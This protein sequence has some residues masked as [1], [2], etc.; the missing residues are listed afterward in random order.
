MINS[1]KVTIFVCLTSAWLVNCTGI[2]PGVLYKTANTNPAK[3]YANPVSV[4]LSGGLL[5]HM[6]SVPGQLGHSVENADLTG[7]ACSK[8]FLGL[9]AIGDSSIEAAK[10]EGKIKKIDRIEYEQFAIGGILYHSFCTVIKG[11]GASPQPDSKPAT[12]GKKK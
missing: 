5:L 1:F 8:S 3:S 7:T 10:A 4:N 11:S 6:G 12:T 9:I 2:N